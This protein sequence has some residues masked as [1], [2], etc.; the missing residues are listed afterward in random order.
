MSSTD[1]QTDRHIHAQQMRD[2]NERKELK[3][4]NKYRDACAYVCVVGPETVAPPAE[5]DRSEFRCDDGACIPAYLVCDRS[6]D[7]RDD[8]DERDCG[9]FIFILRYCWSLFSVL[10]H[11]ITFRPSELRL[12]SSFILLSPDG[13]FTFRPKLQPTCRKNHLQGSS[14]S[15]LN[16]PLFCLKTT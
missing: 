9:S 4:E 13:G 2:K 10:L 11:H 3:Q 12:L 6:Y 5:C 14:T 15:Q 7:C 8:S 1:S 16:P